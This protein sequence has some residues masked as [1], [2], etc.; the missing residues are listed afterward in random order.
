MQ[1]ARN[2]IKELG[3]HIGLETL[4]LDESGQCSLA[5]DETIVLTFV[6]DADDGLNVVSYVGELTADNASAAPL[7]LARNFVPNGLGGGRVAMEPDSARVV[8]VHRWDG[9]RTDFS[10]FTASLESFVNAV[11]QVRGELDNAPSATSAK[12]AARA[13]V[14][15]PGAFA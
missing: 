1:A 13:D 4:E 10:S 15:P 3:R 9:V 6:G 2:L 14:P 12:A 11:E 8:L 5:F 7:L